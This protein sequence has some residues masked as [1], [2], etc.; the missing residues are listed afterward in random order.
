M[1]LSSKKILELVKSMMGLGAPIQRDNQGFNRIDFARLEDFRYLDNLTTKQCLMAL[2]ILVKYKK[3]QLLDFADDLEETLESY[4]EKVKKE[5]EYIPEVDVLR[6][7][8]DGIV[9]R[10]D[11]SKKAYNK[12]QESFSKSDGFWKKNDFGDWE[13]CVLYESVKKFVKEM[14]GILNTTA[15]EKAFKK[16]SAKGEKP[17]K[18]IEAI[19]DEDSIDTLIIKSDFDR[20]L[21]DVFKKYQCKWVPSKKVWEIKFSKFIDFCN[22]IP[23]DKFDK[24]SLAEWYNLFNSWNHSPELIDVSK[25]TTL[26]WT[27][28]EFQIEDAQKLLALKTGLNGNEMGCGKTFEQV[29]I[30]ESI[31]MPKLVICPALLRLNWEREIQMVNPDADISIIYNDEPFKVGKDWTIIGY[32]SLAKFQTELEK[33]RFQVIMI[34]EAHY[35]QAV[36]NSGKPDSQR[37]KVALRLVAT[38]EFVYPIT[39]TPK[40]NR[41][42]NL[43][44]ILRTIRHPLTQKRN[45]FFEYAN[46]FCDGKRNKFGWDFD[47]NSNDDILNNE[48]K[49]V[50]IRHLKKEVLPDLIKM[51]QAIPLKVNLKEYYR[52]IEEYKREKENKAIALA[53]LTKAKQSIAIQKTNDTIE[54]ASQFV[55]QGEKVVIVTCF[56]DVINKVCEKFKCLKIVGGMSDK[57]KQE[58]FDKFQNDESIK[59]IAINILAGGVGIT[60]TASH[61]MIINDIPWTTGELEQVEDRICRS[62]QTETSMIYY[63]I[64]DGCKMDDYLQDLIAKKSVTINTAIDGGFGDTID[65]REIMA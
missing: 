39:G 22:D 56:K 30:G 26:K 41:N 11:Y 10:W 3:R 16:V 29:I 9:V 54:F 32:P 64:A 38:S 53:C 57:A 23:E 37:A 15:L 31:N 34:D 6:E 12:M 43:Y 4:N 49:P 2:K 24:S 44:N 50:M 40:T 19:R 28:Y 61:N 52:Y 55:E 14:K 46:R 7:T 51:R 59:V 21:V 48:I 47:G 5:E 1:I 63:M 62:G 20:N 18:K 13:Y 17:K 36:S 60:L 27:P 33:E 25:I 58:A 35:L 8:S 42:K 45:A 65:F